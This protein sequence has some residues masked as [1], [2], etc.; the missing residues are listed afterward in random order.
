[1]VY[2]VEKGCQLLVQ[3][4]EIDARGT[5]GEGRGC[6][7]DGW[8]GVPV[9]RLLAGQLV[10]CVCVCVAGWVGEWLAGWVRD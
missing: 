5:A 6:W 4:K 10:V 8:L 7:L 3:L 9:A 2:S 1:M